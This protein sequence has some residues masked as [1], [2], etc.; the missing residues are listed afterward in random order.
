MASLL[1]LK[2]V[3]YR[4]STPCESERLTQ[5]PLC[6][7]SFYLKGSLKETTAFVKDAPWPTLFLPQFMFTSSFS[8]IQVFF[9]E[10]SFIEHYFGAKYEYQEIDAFWMTT[11]LLFEFRLLVSLAASFSLSCVEDNLQQRFEY[12]RGK[13][14]VYSRP[15]LTRFK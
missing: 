3:I 7:S 8:Q 10:S 1:L 4:E 15:S 6:Q 13:G 12:Q 14:R 9:R 2:K 5:F 11:L